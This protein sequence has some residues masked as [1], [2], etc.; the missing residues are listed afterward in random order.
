[1][2]WL[3]KIKGPRKSR[4]DDKQNGNLERAWKEAMKRAAEAKRTK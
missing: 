2:N 1:M 3:K 4:R